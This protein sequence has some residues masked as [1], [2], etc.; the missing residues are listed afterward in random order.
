MVGPTYGAAD[1]FVRAVAERR[2]SVHGVH[3]MTLIQLAG[4]LSTGSMARLKLAPLS[5]LG[6]EAL[7][8]RSVF[9]CRRESRLEYFDPV[10]GTPGFPRALAA[11]LRELRL[12][13]VR[14]E[15]LSAAGAP[16]PDLARLLAAYEGELESR[17]LADL[18]VLLRLSTECARDSGHRLVGLPL[19]I[20][21]LSLNSAAERSLVS[22]LVQSSPRVVATALE[23]DTDSI[24]ALKLILGLPQNGE[25]D[26]ASRPSMP[27]VDR[28]LNHLRRHIF[29]TTP[30][31]RRK[32]DASVG[33]FSAAGEGPECVEIARRIRFAAGQGIPFDAIT[34]LL[35]NPEVYL[36]LVE[37]ALGRAGIPVYSTEGVIRPNPA[38][39][40]FLALLDC[41]AEGLSATRFAEY[42]SLGQVPRL[43]PS[44]EPPDAA[45]VWVG[46]RDEAQNPGSGG[47]L[48]D[49]EDEETGG[50]AVEPSAATDQSPVIEGTLRTPF[51]W[52][53]LLIDAAVIGGKDRWARRLDG[54]RY[55]FEVRL[56]ELSPDED[57]RRT[58]LRKQHERLD[59]LKR[60]ALPVIELLA[61]L[62]R[63]ASWGEWLVHLR[64]LAEKTLRDPAPLL[65]MLS[66]LEPMDEVGPAELPEIRQVLAER[67][68]LLREKPSSRRWGCVFVG[69]IE[70]AAGRSFEMVFV[71]GLAEGVFPRK[72]TEDPLLL[73]EH[74]R[75]LNYQLGTALGT[76]DQ[77]RLRERLLMEA[78]AGAAAEQFCVSYP[79]MDLMQGRERVPSFYALEVLRAAEGSLPSLGEIKKRFAESS[80]AMLGWPAPR[81]PEHAI[82][83]AE[84]DLA[85]LE[86]L[87]RRPRK[88][89]WGAARYLL[90]LNE[91][92]ARSLRTRAA[93]WRKTEWTPADGLVSADA[94]TVQALAN[95]RMSMRSYS[96]SALQQFAACPYRF[97]LYAIH[98][99]EE[100]EEPFP[101][102]KMDPLT[103]GGMFHEVQF[104]IFRDLNRVSLLPVDEAE[105][106]L[107]MDIADRILDRVALR[108]EEKLAPAIPPIWRSEL[109]DIRTDLRGWVKQLP[110][111][112][113]E[114]KPIHYEYAFG[115]PPGPA[116]DTERDPESSAQ[117]V[118]ILEGLEG[119][120]VRGSIDLVEEHRQRGVLRITDHKTGKVPE[121]TPSSVG[122]GE[123]LQPVLYGLAAQKLLGKRVES[124]VL[125]YCTQRGNY[126]QIVIDLNQPSINRLQLVVQTIDKAMEQGFLPAAPREGAC[127]Y[128]EY[129]IVCGPREEIRIRRKPQDRLD[130][131]NQLRCQP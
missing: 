8:A 4:M 19:F 131:L 99:L 12:E 61:S 81:D 2:G 36:P 77:R 119:L 10:A 59:D 1:D 13:G 45:G 100:R 74:R 51:A 24:T 39:R 31:P 112:H 52:E 22:A 14:P 92:L 34:I 130:E 129:R 118:P 5:R 116:R 48:R 93:R 71:P 104:E 84:H 20:I 23:A 83:N 60:F 30:P 97:L 49:V 28:S 58:Y 80:G 56:R 40:A 9:H 62:P 110:S 128:C 26:D 3:R 126:Q 117:P 85:V 42:L 91:C 105:L 55:Q 37:D 88:E 17:A 78:A 72:P 87:V 7:A 54:L 53:E 16:G 98:D 33:F 107:V 102:E 103:R 67:L 65:E 70:E 50:G 66:E 86:R 101:I 68:R 32:L 109:E 75:K 46:S 41:A 89:A 115:L 35:R 94:V 64:R 125:Y 108:W 27:V 11:T 18:A 57:S 120:T 6:M 124:G 111:I 127:R 69:S 121:R 90:D 25:A 47:A 38:G 76:Q 106:P 29:R 43:K 96:A 82:D 122:E 79:R 15:G 63:A 114:W 95:Q 44:G 73:D 113:A 21:D 123:I